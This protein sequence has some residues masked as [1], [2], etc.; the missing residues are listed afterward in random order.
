ML[1]RSNRLVVLLPEAWEERR[2]RALTLAEL[3][4]DRAAAEDL[5]AYLQHCGDAEDAPALRE[6]L[7]ELQRANSGPLH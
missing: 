1:F 4:L 6:R 3:G 5:T 2:D 7:R